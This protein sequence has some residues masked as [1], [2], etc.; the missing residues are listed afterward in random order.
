MCNRNSSSPVLTNVTISGNSAS[1][2][3]G[4][5]NS[6]SSPVLTNVTISDNFAN[7]STSEGGGMYNTHSSSPVLTDVTI[8]GNSASAGGG[9]YNGYSSSPVLTNV[10]ISG[11]SA[12][13]SWGGG[14]YNYNSSSPVLTNVTISGNYAYTYGGGISNNNNC[15]PVLT[16]VTLSGNYA[17]GTYGSGGGGM[18]N[19]TDS[20]PKIRNSIVWGNTASA[21]GP[22]VYNNSS[23]P[24]F[25]YSI[26]QGSGGSGAWVGSFGTNG[27]DNLDVD[28]EFEEWKDPSV[29]G[30]VATPHGDYRLK[31]SPPS[32]A[33]N[34]GSDGLYPAN[35]DDAIF[36][37]SLS[38]ELKAAISSALQHD[39]AGNAR[40]QGT[41]DMGAYETQ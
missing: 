18:C 32:P 9:M 4:M 22:N 12:S 39:L 40:P 38:A 27:G 6:G 11:N 30:W 20:A 17:N 19:L 15:S 33:I 41:I 8:S 26:V 31:S 13:T 35:A 10:T 36:P 34:A 37:A 14:M 2:A 3:G 29:P 23:T 24:V 25:T 5:Y 1:A 16:N 28:P 21:G 7:G